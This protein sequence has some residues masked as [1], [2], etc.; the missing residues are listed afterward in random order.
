M[1]YTK[2]DKKKIAQLVEKTAKKYGLPIVTKKSKK[3]STQ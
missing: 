1:K 2:E 3:K